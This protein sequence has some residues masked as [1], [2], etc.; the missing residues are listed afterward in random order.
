MRLVNFVMILKIQINIIFMGKKSDMAPHFCSAKNLLQKKKL[1][2][3]LTT[4]TF[5]KSKSVVSFSDTLSFF[6]P[7]GLVT[8]SLEFSPDTVIIRFFILLS[9]ISFV[10]YGTV[11][12]SGLLTYIKFTSQLMNIDDLINLRIF[13]TS[14][15]QISKTWP[16]PSDVILS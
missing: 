8:L 7:F 3:T 11:L 12:L 10:E 16:N 6:L 4:F 13:D 14:F 9:T 1:T 2:L 15:L 5:F